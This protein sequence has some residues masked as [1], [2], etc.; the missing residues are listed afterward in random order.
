MKRQLSLL[1][2][3][4]FWLAGSAEAQRPGRPSGDP[5]DPII[6]TGSRLTREQA[7]EQA[8]DYVRQVGVARGLAPAARWIDPVCPRVRGIAEP[9]A[10]I[11][12]ARMR[13][14]AQET[15]I[16]TADKGCHPNISVSFVGNA[17]ALMKVIGRRSPIRFR[18]VPPEARE[19]LI[20]GDLPI[21]WWYLTDERTKGG[22][23]RVPHSIPTTGA[24]LQVEAFG[25][26]NSSIVGTQMNRAIVEA[27]VVIDLD[28]VEGRRLDAI[29]AYAAFVAFAEVRAGATPPAGS[30]LG[31]FGRDGEPQGGGLTK[32]DRT[33]LR[34][35]YRLPLDR[36]ARRLRGRLV[37]D[38]VE[39]QAAE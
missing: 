5:D 8:G 2:C 22:V 31:M 9:Y 39:A 23:S 11:V 18:E 17:E 26:Y 25:H 27:G 35:L 38:M 13:G 1:A 24:P 21:R 10:R 14:I 34:A 36:T 6:V 16:Q 3:A 28:R 4:G 19:A 7:R 12:E 20:N 37:S 32:H 29:A 30:V 15:G 33:F